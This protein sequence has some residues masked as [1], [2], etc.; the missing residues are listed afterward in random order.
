[1]EDFLYGGALRIAGLEFLDE[2]PRSD[3]HWLHAS[4]GWMSRI[5]SVLVYQYTPKQSM[6]RSTGTREEHSTGTAD[7]FCN[8]TRMDTHP[9]QAHAPYPYVPS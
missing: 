6:Q 4:P 7:P 9:I 1:M 2:N 8:V 3:F 5:T